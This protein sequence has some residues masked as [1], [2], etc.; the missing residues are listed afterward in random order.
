GLAWLGLAWLGL[1]WL[2]LAWLKP[3]LSCGAP[4]AIVKPRDAGATLRTWAARPTCPDPTPWETARFSLM[5]TS[6][7]SPPY[8]AAPGSRA[9][10]HPLRLSLW[11]L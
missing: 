6:I 8:W 7:V 1:A 10:R 2:G 11:H 4:T 9:C 3:S 5:H